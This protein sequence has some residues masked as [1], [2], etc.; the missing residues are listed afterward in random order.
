MITLRRTS[1]SSGIGRSYKSKRTLFT[2]KQVRPATAIYGQRRLV[3]RRIGVSLK[4]HRTFRI[5]GR[6]GTK[7]GF[8][9]PG[10]RVVPH[11]ELRSIPTAQTSLWHKVFLYTL[12][13][14]LPHGW[15]LGFKSPYTLRHDLLQSIASSYK[16]EGLAQLAEHRHGMSAVTGSNPVS[17]TKL[18]AALLFG[19]KVFL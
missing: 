6:H 3:W 5:K 13:G 7:S 9:F 17:L 4:R 8:L 16:L 15:M 19:H 1:S 12:V 18:L 11:H 14:F 2:K 10:G